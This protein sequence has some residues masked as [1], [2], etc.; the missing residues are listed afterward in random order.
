MIVFTQF[1]S[2]Y[3]KGLFFGHHLGIGVFYA[4]DWRRLDPIVLRGKD[5]HDFVSFTNGRLVADTGELKAEHDWLDGN[6]WGVPRDVQITVWK[7][8]AQSVVFHFIA[9]GQ[10]AEI[11]AIEPNRKEGPFAGFPTS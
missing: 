2:S 7:G 4:Q 1:Q 5:I 9:I 8:G 3:C 6:T 11:G 10:F